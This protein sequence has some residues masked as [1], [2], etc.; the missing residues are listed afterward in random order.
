MTS[1]VVQSLDLA[2]DESV[3]RT[4]TVCASVG[5]VLADDLTRRFP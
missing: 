5:V 1:L 4:L 2:R 3:S